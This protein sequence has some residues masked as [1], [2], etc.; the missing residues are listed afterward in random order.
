[1]LLPLKAVTRSSAF[2]LTFA[3]SEHSEYV[4]LLRMHFG[5]ALGIL[6][7]MVKTFPVVWQHPLGKSGE[8]L[9][10]VIFFSTIKVILKNC[11]SYV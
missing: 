1:M 10:Y 2:Q 11:A 7:S 6:L 4:L 9:S 8:K 5:V 3:H